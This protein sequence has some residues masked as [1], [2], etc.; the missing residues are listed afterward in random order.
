M[1]IIDGWGFAAAVFIGTGVCAFVS[2]AVYYTT[3]TVSRRSTFKHL[4]FGGIKILTEKYDRTK[5]ELSDITFGVDLKNSSNNTIFYK[6]RR[7]DHSFGGRINQI[8]AFDFGISVVPPSSY[9][10]IILA[11]IPGPIPASCARGGQIGKVDV[12]LEYGPDKDRL[13]YFYRLLADV[14]IV[15][16]AVNAFGDTEFHVGVSVKEASHQRGAHY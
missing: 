10:T 9:N 8:A 14:Q 1:A 12:E 2:A 5:N 7:S 16:A 13:R 15:V 6:I 3:E 11:T 4:N